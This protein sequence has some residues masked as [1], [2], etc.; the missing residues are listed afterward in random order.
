MFYGGF[1]KCAKRNSR[2]QYYKKPKEKTEILPSRISEM[3]GEI[4]LK[5]GMWAPLSGGQL[6][7]TSGSNLLRR[8]IH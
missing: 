4:F 8:Y 7:S 2:I 1:A 5:S 3:T 6:Y